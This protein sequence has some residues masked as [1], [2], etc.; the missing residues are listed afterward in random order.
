MIQKI[1]DAI[2]HVSSGRGSDGSGRVC[3][4][5]KVSDNCGAKVYNDFKVAKQN[6]E[7]QQAL[8]ELGIAPEVLSDVIEFKDMNTQRFMFL[9]ELAKTVFEVCIENDLAGDCCYDGG[10][11]CVCNGIECNFLDHELFCGISDLFIKMKELELYDCDNHWGNYGYL[12]DGTA[13]II[14][15]EFY[16]RT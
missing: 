5:Y 16:H 6:M 1:S 11:N 15:C 12:K 9:T 13:V 4:F 14:D 2:N 10:C 3:N 7:S 8:Y